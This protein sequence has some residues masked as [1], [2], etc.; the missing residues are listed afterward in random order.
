MMTQTGHRKPDPELSKSVS[1]P[2]RQWQDRSA[3]TR[4]RCRWHAEGAP[5]LEDQPKLG[6][7]PSRLSPV[8]IIARASSVGQKR[9][10][11]DPRPLECPALAAYRVRLP[12][13]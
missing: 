8:V 7:R 12:R 9:V 6:R 1:A 10:L 3:Q 2:R 4:D 13:V 11:G 5:V